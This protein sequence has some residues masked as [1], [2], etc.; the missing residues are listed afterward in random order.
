MRKGRILE[1]QQGRKHNGKSKNIGTYYSLSF[2]WVLY[3]FIDW[4]KNYNT[5]WYSRQWYFTLGK[6]KGPRWKK[7]FLYSFPQSGKMLKPVRCDVTYEYCNSSRAITKKT[8]QTHTLEDAVSKLRSKPVVEIGALESAPRVSGQLN[9][10]KS[11]RLN[12][13]AREHS[14]FIWEEL[15]RLS[16]PTIASTSLHMCM[17]LAGEAKIHLYYHLQTASQMKGK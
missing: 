8:I 5:I 2:S 11:S 15:Y 12:T 7:R 14:I 16:S 3:I 17:C 1:N 4:S 6:V 13:I 10:G 9:W